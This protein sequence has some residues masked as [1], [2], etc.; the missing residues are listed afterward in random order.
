MRRVQWIVLHCS[1]SDVPAHDNI[2]TIKKWHTLPRI[3]KEIEEGIKDGKL[4][5]SEA[6]KYGNGWKDVG[7]HYFIDKAGAL[8]PG[9]SE[10]TIGA[11]VA[12]HNSRSIGICLSGR[13]LFTSDQFHSLGELLKDLCGKYG[14][15]KSDILGH[16]DLESGKTCPN[17][18]VEK[19]LESLK[20]E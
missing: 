4:P 20:W 12:G 11:H 5:K 3:P 16:C 10:D 8:F 9:R 1:D 15:K 14:L 19:F 2:E 7:Y 18:N 17:F 13:K 6:F